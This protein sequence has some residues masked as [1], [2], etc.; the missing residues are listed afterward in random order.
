[1]NALDYADVKSR[2]Q[3]S[4]P[5]VVDELYSFGE[6]L[7]SD[8]VDRLS[9]SD[10]KASALA[11]YCGGLVTLVASTSAFW[12]KYLDIYS[13]MATV[14]AVSLFIVSAWLA[15]G[16]THPQATEWYS[17]N[18]WFREGCLQ[19]R[20]RL[21]RYRVLTMWRILTSHQEAFRRKT[22]RVRNAVLLLKI[23]SLLLL[24][25]FLEIAWRYAPLQNL[26]IRI[27]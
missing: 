27:W 5:E 25:T 20:E 13:L 18:D 7:V 6:K 15:A 17:D 11:G 9:K 3:N 19:A 1:M 14:V 24:F 26:R 10:S 4:A 22:R 23:A 8:A 21:R 2:V 12:G 16:S